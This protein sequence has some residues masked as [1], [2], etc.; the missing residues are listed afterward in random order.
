VVELVGVILQPAEYIALRS[1]QCPH[2]DD[3]P[4]QKR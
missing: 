2:A 4:D 1:V 3:A